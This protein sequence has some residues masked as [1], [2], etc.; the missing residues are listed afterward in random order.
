MSVPAYSS[1]LM[2]VAPATIATSTSSNV[3]AGYLWVVRNIDCV[4]AGVFGESSGGKVTV[5]DSSGCLIWQVSGYGFTE[6]SHAQW[7]GR[8]VLVAGD[9]LVVVTTTP[10]ASVRI[11]GYAL[12]V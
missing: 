1:V 4:I 6:N 12:T 5:A 9:H 10:G 8:Q 11:S 3:P 7:E 2:K